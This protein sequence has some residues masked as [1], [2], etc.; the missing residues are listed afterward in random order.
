MQKND[1]T[2]KFISPMITA[3]GI[4]LGF[5]LAFTA[6]WVAG[7]PNTADWSDAII[8]IGLF[9]SIILHIHA[10]YRV[11]DNEVEDGKEHSHYR[12]TLRIFIIGLIIALLSLGISTIQIALT[13]V[14]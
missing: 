10:M 3:V 8:G 14:L 6:S 1:S 12:K 5:L 13:P 11:L 2:E 4:I 9:A 7:L